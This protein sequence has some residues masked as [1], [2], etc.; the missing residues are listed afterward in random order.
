MNWN[1]VHIYLPIK[2]KSRTIAANNIP[3]NTMTVNNFFTHCVKE[4]EIKR[5]RENLQIL[6]TNKATEI[7][8]YSDAILKYMS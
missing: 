4:I 3:A 8:R 1:S 7:Y 6:L 2:I 5:C